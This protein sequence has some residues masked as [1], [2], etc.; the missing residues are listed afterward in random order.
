MPRLECKLD[1]LDKHQRLIFHA[2]QRYPLRTQTVSITRKVVRPNAFTE[3][4]K[5][6]VPRAEMEGSLR[7]SALFRQELQLS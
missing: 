6:T 2:G 5:T 7:L 4:A 1:L 3:V